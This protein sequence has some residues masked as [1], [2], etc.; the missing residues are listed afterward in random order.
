MK[1]LILFTFIGT[2]LFISCK[3]ENNEPSGIVIKEQMSVF[4]GD[5][6]SISKSE[7]NHNTDLKNIE[8]LV[9]SWYYLD[10]KWTLIPNVNDATGAN[11]TVDNSGNVKI[12]L[13]MA[14]ID[15]SVL[16]RVVLK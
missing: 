1:K 15:P 8:Y 9:Q 12:V 10:D 13:N 16:V 11:I 4:D 5:I 3:K 7:I 2:T 14:P 6:I